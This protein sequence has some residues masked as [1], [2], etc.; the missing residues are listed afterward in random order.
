MR[1]S[2]LVYAG[3]RRRSALLRKVRQQLGL[4]RPAAI[5]PYRGYGTQRQ[6]VIS[7]RIV[8]G[9]NVKPSEERRT[10][11]ESAY[12]SYQRYATNEVP[13]AEVTVRWQGQRWTTKTDEE[14][15]VHLVVEPPAVRAGWHEVELSLEGVEHARATGYVFVIDETTEYG[16][17]SDIDDT[18][19][20][21]KVTHPLKRAYALFLSEARTRLPFEGVGA[22]YSALHEGTKPEITNPIFYVSSSP[23][24]L[25]EHIDEFLRIHDIPYGTVLLRDWGLSATGFAPNGKHTHKLDK[26]RDVFERT[27]PLPYILI[28]DSGQHDPEL[29]AQVVSAFPGRVKAVY[30]RSAHTRKSRQE[31]LQRIGAEIS[32]RGVSFLVV[33]DTVAAA[34]HAAKSGYILGREIEHVARERDEMQQR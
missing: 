8:E 30:I 6:V 2:E 31:E 23:W 32:G 24:N 10:L 26:I 13:N 27:Q 33:D 17:I 20:D 11:F 21:T 1:V 29:Y 4:A 3:E 9:R 28:G 12:A 5:L 16:V 14:G 34:E 25:Y 7:A 22:F 15:F 18:V 19:I